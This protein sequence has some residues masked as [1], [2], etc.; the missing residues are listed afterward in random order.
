MAGSGKDIA[1]LHVAVSDNDAV[2]QEFDER[3]P[4][5]EARLV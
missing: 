2:N 1:D 3:S 4:L 5:L